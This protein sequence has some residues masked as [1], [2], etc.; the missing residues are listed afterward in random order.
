MLLVYGAVLF[1][2]QNP[3]FCVENSTHPQLIQKHDHALFVILDEWIHSIHIGLLV[4]KKENHITLLFIY[5]VRKNENTQ[6]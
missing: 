1:C 5:N 4:H 2:M 3:P 6:V